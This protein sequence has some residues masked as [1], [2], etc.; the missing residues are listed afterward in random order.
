MK[1]ETAIITFC[2][3]VYVD[4]YKTP[5]GEYRVGSV[6]ASL[7]LG[8][9][10]NWVL[11]VTS[12]GEKS[13]K[14]LQDMGFE[15]YILSGEVDR[16]QGGKSGVKTLSLDNFNILIEYAVSKGKKPAI[17]LSNALR[18]VSL[19]VFF[20]DGFGDEPMGIDEIRRVFYR[21]YAQ[22]I[23]WRREDRG[24]VERLDLPGDPEELWGWYES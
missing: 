7:A 5:E 11:R 20:R 24:D 1:L 6:G 17:A 9:A 2:E 4:G 3:G 15:G 19:E 14:T 13:L 8:Y 10:R 16:R 23:D 12:K 22:S 21:S 18:R